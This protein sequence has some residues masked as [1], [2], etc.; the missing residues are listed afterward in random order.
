ML[1]FKYCPLI[2]IFCFK[3]DNKFIHKIHK[4]TL[5]LI[6]D[7]E[8]ASF[9]DLLE[10]DKPRTT[11]VL[12]KLTLLVKIYKSIDCITPHL[13]QIFFFGLKRNRYHCRSNYLLK[14]PD[15]STP[16]YGTQPLCF[17]GSLLWNQIPIKYKS[18]SSPD[19]FESQI[20]QW[21]LL[22]AAA[23]FVNR[24]ILEFL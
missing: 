14:L 20:K 8:D 11:H 1:T 15:A 6:Y 16:Q 21:N 17:K 9:E 13:K 12:N 23:N 2:C 22:P 7:T 19:G 18:L 10:R 4:R 3:T 24:Q 5:R